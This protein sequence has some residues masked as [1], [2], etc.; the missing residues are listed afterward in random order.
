MGIG[1]SVK[2]IEAMA[3]GVPVVATDVGGVRELIEDVQTGKD[4]AIKRNVE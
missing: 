4:L 2:I 3:A 1:R